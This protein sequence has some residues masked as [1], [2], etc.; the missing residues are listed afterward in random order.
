MLD[1]HALA[2][3]F[4]IPGVVFPLLAYVLNCFLSI[5]LGWILLPACIYGHYWYHNSWRVPK[6]IP[7][8]DQYNVIVVGAGMS[9]LCAGAKLL[10]AGVPFT[11]L[12][13]GHEIGGTWH[14][15]TYP[16]CACDV[17]TTLYQFTFFQNPQW[18]RFV[19][20]AQEIKQYLISF[21]KNFGLKPHIQFE[22]SVKTATWSQN[23]AM[24]TIV[25]NKGE[26]KCRILISACGA[27]HKP[28]TPEIEGAEQFRGD[29]FHSSNWNHGVDITGKKVGI[30]GS[31]ASAVQ[32]APSISD[33]VD[34]LYVF[35][36]TPNW[37]FPKFDPIY[38]EEL[39]KIFKIF[40]FLMT[41][42]RL[43]FFFLV[44]GWSLVWLRKGRLSEWFQIIIESG[45]RKQAGGNQSLMKKIIPDYKLGCKRILLTSEFIPMFNKPNCHLITD[46]ISKISKNGIQTKKKESIKLD[47]I[48]YATGFDVEAS[49]CSFDTYGK[50]NKKLRDC[51]DENP[52]AYLGMTVPDFPNFFF[53]FGPNTVLAHSSVLWM[54]ECQVDYIIMTIQSMANLHLKSVEVRRDKTEDFQEKMGQWT[55]NKN[56]STTCKSWYKNKDGKNFVL[57]PSN[58]LQYWWM[59]FKPDILNDYKIEVFNEY[60]ST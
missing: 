4:L 7:R 6:K 29:S 20:S 53:V 39:K 40:P 38:P 30:V 8:R 13:S 2:T 31:A 9:G 33:K 10:Q 46:P 36:R 32:I 52:C 47:T 3:Y 28:I 5:P 41:I 59:T 35:Q 1:R 12:E 23:E 57:W 58:L 43:F 50:D 26:M 44:E 24:W 55:L 42:Q 19:A 48:I 17:W 15:N 27:L 60:F 49:F 51:L 37:Y 45:M 25:T 18:S 16:G 14:F 34:S 22:T 56:F 54:I 21:T 11:I